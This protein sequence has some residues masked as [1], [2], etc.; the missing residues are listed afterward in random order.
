MHNKESHR[1]D[2]AGSGCQ[3]KCG[4]PVLEQYWHE[5]CNDQR[6]HLVLGH[7]HQKS[8]LQLRRGRGET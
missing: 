5:A 2:V 1:A 3:M 8:H 6:V 4:Y 7:L